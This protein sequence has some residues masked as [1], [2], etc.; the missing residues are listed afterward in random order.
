MTFQV[1]TY[2]AKLTNGGHRFCTSLFPWP[3]VRVCRNAPTLE[4]LD[5]P[6][7]DIL[8]QTATL[9]FQLIPDDISRP[10]SLNSEGPNQT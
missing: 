3:G 9:V 4:I 2:C 10:T 5:L 6:P 1:I 7:N 8:I